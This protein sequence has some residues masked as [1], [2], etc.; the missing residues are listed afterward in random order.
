MN[1]KPSDSWQ[2][3]D[4]LF[5]EL[6]AEFHFDA[7]LCATEHNSKC[8]NYCNDYLTETIDHM[9]NESNQT[10]FMNP[11]Y[12]NPK[13]FIQKAW[14]DARYCKIVCLVKC[15]P[16][17]KWWATFWEYTQ[18]DYRCGVCGTS[19]IVGNNLSHYLCLKCGSNSTWSA[20]RRRQPGPKPGCEVRFFPKR[21]KFDPPNKLQLEIK[22]NK[23]KVVC[24]DFETMGSSKNSF[25]D[26]SPCTGHNCLRCKGTGFRWGNLAG[27]S[28][29]CAL[30]IMD[31]R[32]L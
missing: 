10:F 28:F 16:S 21:I 31:R 32:G 24:D 12:S 1:D 22:G 18:N 14:Q 3:P 27:A 23:Y 25:L 11:P 13:P 30:V 29:P 7:D 20:A 4:W 26:R 2:T 15:D 19:E 9:F 6:D 17:T 5:K 8:F